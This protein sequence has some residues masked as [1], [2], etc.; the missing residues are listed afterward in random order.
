MKKEIP[1]IKGIFVRQHIQ[2]IKK[3]KGDEGVKLLEQKFGRPL[4]FKNS[5]NVPIAD[6]IKILESFTEILFPKNYTRDEL[7]YV[8]GRLHFKNFTQSPIARILIY[9]FKMDFR[10]LILNSTSIFA[11]VFNNVPFSAESL[12]KNSVKVIIS[13]GYAKDHFRGFFDEWF[14]YS[15]LEGTTLAQ[16]EN[17]DSNSYMLKWK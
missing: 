15:G 1:S 5:D 8:S 14:E 13:N 3:I 17:V 10:K 7:Q 16:T 9:S 11:H 4:V 6:E 12:G 2:A